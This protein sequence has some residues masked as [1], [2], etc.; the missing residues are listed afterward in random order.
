MRGLD[1]NILVQIG[2]IVL[3][4]LAAKNAILIVEFARQ[5]QERGLSAV[6]AA[7]EACRL[8]LRPILMTAFAFILG[9]VPLVIATGPGAEMRQSLGTAVF[10]GMLGVTLFGLFLTP[11]F[12][13][14][15]RSP[16]SRRKPQ[17]ETPPTPTEIRQR[18]S[19]ALFRDQPSTM[20]R[21]PCRRPLGGR[22]GLAGDAARQSRKSARRGVKLSIRRAGLQRLDAMHR[23]GRHDEGAAGAKRLG[24]AVDR[25]LEQALGD[26]ARLHM[27]MRMQGTDAALLEGEFDGHQRLGVKD[28]AAAVAVAEVGPVAIVRACKQFG[29][30]HLSLII[31]P[32]SRHRRR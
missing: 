17:V 22:E 26:V 20:S 4:G 13:V 9:V 7:V 1:N 30:V 12:Y 24:V 21:V 32:A 29:V 15:L 11:V 31:S 8:R 10:S 3:I 6:D 19:K 28:D 25:H 16:S 14:T 5:A 27:R 18:P 23:V 2:L